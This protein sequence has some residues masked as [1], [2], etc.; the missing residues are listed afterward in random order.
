MHIG[1]LG[2]NTGLAPSVVTFDNE[3]SLNHSS[4][5]FQVLSLVTLSHGLVLM[6]QRLCVSESLG[7]AKTKTQTSGPSSQ[8]FSFRRS[9][10]VPFCILSK[11]PG[12]ADAGHPETTF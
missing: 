1:V 4:L 3:L 6:F 5:A 11:F 10:E 9:S 8:N 7:T 2:I 12:N